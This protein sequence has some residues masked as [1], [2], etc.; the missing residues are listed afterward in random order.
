[1]VSRGEWRRRQL[2]Q[3]LSANLAGL[4]P[5]YAGQYVCPLCMIGGFTEADV[6]G[7]SPLLTEEHCIPDGLGPTISVLTCAKCNNTAGAKLDNEL[8]KRTEWDAFCNAEQKRPFKVRLS[9]DENNLGIELSRTGDENP[10]MNIKVIAR[11]SNEA[12]IKR[13]QE[14]FTVWKKGGATPGPMKIHF[15]T[16]VL[17][18][19]RLARIA[20]L[21]AGYLLLFKRFG[22]YPITLTIFEPIRRQIRDFQ[23][24]QLNV[25]SIVLRY[26]IESLPETTCF[27]RTPSAVGV[28]V[29]VAFSKYG[30]GYFVIMPINEST[31]AEWDNFF[32]LNQE[33]GTETFPCELYP[34]DQEE[35]RENLL[36]HSAGANPASD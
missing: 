23:S 5:E 36:R 6:L 3:E 26:P 17:P 24:Q 25:E 22:Y 27:M 1:M 8:H 15:R 18:R 11:Q 9:G 20:L 14:I 35:I 4:R 2:F 33:S 19:E 7:A 10:T 29:P 30:I 34:L 32:N 21:K 16:N 13:H 31:Y 12:D 28:A